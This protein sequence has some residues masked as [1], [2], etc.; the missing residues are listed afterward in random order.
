M[1]SI[2]KGEPGR[3]PKHQLGGPTSK[4]PGGIPSG[5]SWSRN[6]RVPEAAPK[7]PREQGATGSGAPMAGRTGG[8]LL[9]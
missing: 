3:D 8:S 9:E 6:L 1:G 2:L 4:G 5:I 7:E